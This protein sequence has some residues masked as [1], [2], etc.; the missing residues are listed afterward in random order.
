MA[1]HCCGS[2]SLPHGEY[3]S[4]HARTPR[5]TY[6]LAAL[7]L[8]AGKASASSVLGVA[9]L[10]M[11]LLNLGLNGYN[12]YKLRGVSKLQKVGQS[13]WCP[14]VSFIRQ[15]MLVRLSRPSWYVQE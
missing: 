1:V 12:T 7:L 6:I 9:N 15:C 3:L 11:G 4:A 2:V 14:Y 5:S 8:L 10:A 13:C